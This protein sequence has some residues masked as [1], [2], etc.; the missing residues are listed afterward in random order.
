MSFPQLSLNT[1]LRNFQTAMYVTMVI[2]MVSVYLAF[3]DTNYSLII[4]SLLNLSMI[5]MKLAQ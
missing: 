5:G 2:I 1:V 4:N 3:P